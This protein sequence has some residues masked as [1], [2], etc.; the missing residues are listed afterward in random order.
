MKVAGG[1]MQAQRSGNRENPN[2]EG[3]ARMESGSRP[4]SDVALPAPGDNIGAKYDLT[5]ILGS[6]AMGVVYEAIHTRLHQRLAI[7]V[8]RPDVKDFHA[9]VERF[10]REAHATARLR[11]VH[12]ARVIDVDALPNGLPYI[13]MEYLEG[14][15]L[16]AELSAVGPMPVEVAVDIV[17]QVAQAMIEA[18]SLGIIHRDLKPANVFV[19]RVGGRAVAKVLDFGISKVEDESRLTGAGEWFGTPSYSSPEQMQAVVEAD[20]RCDVWSL[21]VILFE[22]LTGR[23]PFEGSTVQVI[24]QVLMNP[25][26]WPV[27][28]RPDLPPDLARIVMK[29]LE[30]DREKRFQSM[31]EMADVL[32]PFGPVQSASSVLGELQRSRGRLGEILVNDGLITQADLDRALAAQRS[33]GRLLGKVLLDL[34]LVT[35]ADLLTAVAKQQGLPTADTQRNILARE[36]REREAETLSPPQPVAESPRAPPSRSR[37][38]VA[39]VIVIAL[40]AAFVLGRSSGASGSAADGP[41]ARSHS[42][43]P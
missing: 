5:R 26:P 36:R 9:V 29:A 3:A 13:V 28:L 25:V 15:G 27:T 11:S 33:D 34:G 2:T 14:R 16:D 22:L 7:K 35:H 19:C 8:L 17:S 6:G 1:F 32:A 39:G 41:A 20:A 38:L 40:A 42:V 4:R 37:W 30:R 43:A 12:A 10:E 31:R 18:H 24:T 23:V 21:G